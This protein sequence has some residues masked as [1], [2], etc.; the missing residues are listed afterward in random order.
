MMLNGI[1]PALTTPFDENGALAVDRLRE[2]IIRYNA[3]G[4]S[5]YLVAG[6][7][8]ETPF[9]DRAEFDRL[10]SSVR[11]IEGVARS[12]TSLLLAPA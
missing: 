9:L 10:L 8:G 5:G 7:T 2:N 3:T 4:L 6:S 1:I 12:E 11:M